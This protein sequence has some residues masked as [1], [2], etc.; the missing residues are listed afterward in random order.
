MPNR[1]YLT[2][3]GETHY[4]AEWAAKIEVPEGVITHRLNKLK[5]SVE[6]ALTTPLYKYVQVPCSIEGC[7]RI[8]GSL[9]MCDKHYQ[10]NCAR[11]QGIKE[12][13]PKT[14]QGNPTELDIAY[15]A[16][17]ID[18]EGCISAKRCWY[19]SKGERK[20][21]T[22]TPRVSIIMTSKPVLDWVYFMFGGHLGINNKNT[23]SGKIFYHWELIGK[24]CKQ[25]LQSIQ[26]YLKEK[27]V[28]ASVAIEMCDLIGIA[29][30]TLTEDIKLQ[31]E[32]YWV[33]LNSLNG[34]V[35][36]VSE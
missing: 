10:R 9:G 4:I 23:P 12:R 3:N 1:R 34:G 30:P 5:W 14:P 16:G 2:L 13:V 29:G 24:N 18:G 17:I 36:R 31:R 11:K 26:P 22:Y 7:D 21:R 27:G 6:R 20:N 32:E 28:Q 35:R 8:A 19:I 15:C 25:F 33:K